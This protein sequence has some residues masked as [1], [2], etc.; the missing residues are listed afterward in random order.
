MRRTFT[1][2]GPVGLG[3]R[4]IPFSSISNRSV[5]FSTSVFSGLLA[6]I[7]GITVFLIGIIIFLS[8]LGWSK[9]ASAYV[10]GSMVIM[11]MTTAVLYGS[12]LYDFRTQSRVISYRKIAVGCGCAFLTVIV[13][14]FALKISQEFSRV[15]LFSYFGAS[16]PL[17][18]I[19]HYLVEHRLRRW[20]ISGK[21]ARNVAI[22]G[23]TGPAKR[24]IEFVEKS[25]DPWVRILGVF[26]DRQ[27][28]G[29]SDGCQYPMLGNV[30][31]LISFGRQ[32]R[33]DDIVI[34]LPW[35]AEERTLGIVERLRVLPVSVHLCPD[36][37]GFNF[38]QNGYAYLCGVPVLKVFQ[39]PV[40]GWDYVA[41]A[42]E[43]KV[44]AALFLVLTLPVTVLIAVC[45]KLDSPGPV[46]FRQKRYGFND[47][48]I[49]VYKFRSL[50]VE[51]QDEDAACLVTRND[52]RVT[53]VGSFLRRTSL[54]ELPQLLNVLKGEMSI[55]GPRPHA[56]N[57]SAQGR[58]YHEVVEKYSTRHKVK[59]GI[60]GWA[61]VSGW[62]GETDT[63]EKI[64]KRVEHDIFY[65]ENWSLGLDISIVL[66][67]MW[68]A[69]KGDRA[70]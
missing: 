16:L 64:R 8:Y 63:E 1:E 21:I 34:A 2:S 45:I 57:A 6:A 22:F 32:R 38:V 35:G 68:V 19:V 4:P 65:I 28:P 50:R 44:L 53:R 20:G 41:K 40:S 33:I 15:W 37:I 70:Y 69:L 17:L 55:V 12:G 54:D 67:T 58:L 5:P 3:V 25:Q 7:D 52:T 26:D 61:Q 14:G 56:L 29:R 13:L 11:L 48:L 18:I 49:D 59:P 27:S 36:A 42:I 30:E 66:R 23:G 46:L 62:R 43:D 31:K 47:Q 39:K 51:Q 10:C 24:L 9:N 60:T